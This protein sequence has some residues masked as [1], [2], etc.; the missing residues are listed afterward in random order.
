M[1]AAPGVG[2][3]APQLGYSNQVFVMD[4]DG[5]SYTEVINPRLVPQEV[6]SQILSKEGCLSIP[7]HTGEVIR[8]EQVE[9]LYQD[10][11]GEEHHAVAYGFE[12]T[13]VQHEMDHLA[14]KLFIHK[15]P[16]QQRR[17]IEKRF[18]K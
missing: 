13:I 11:F 4:K 3:A 7:G 5:S 9:L 10:R 8:D 6:P 14:G 15:L 16:R 2:L 17:F 12:A 18:T 1:Y